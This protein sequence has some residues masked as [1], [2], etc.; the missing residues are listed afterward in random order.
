MEADRIDITPIEDDFVEY[1]PTRKSKHPNSKINKSKQK[2]KPKKQHDTRLPFSKNSIIQILDNDNYTIDIKM[3][4]LNDLLVLISF[5]KAQY[6]K[7]TEWSHG[8]VNI[9]PNQFKQIFN[10]RGGAHT[11]SDKIKTFNMPVYAPW[12]ELK[13]GDTPELINRINN[14][15]RILIN[16]SDGSGMYRNY[17][18]EFFNLN[19]N[20]ISLSVLD[21]TWDIDLWLSVLSHIPSI[22]IYSPNMINILA[23]L[24]I[25]V[26]RSYSITLHKDERKK[27]DIY[28]DIKNYIN[29]IYYYMSDNNLFAMDYANY[30]SWPN[31]IKLAM[32]AIT[33][34]EI[35]FYFGSNKFYRINLHNLIYDSPEE[36]IKY[37]INIIYSTNEK[38]TVEKDGIFELE[39]A[40]VI[41]I[42]IVKLIY[43]ILQMPKEVDIKLNTYRIFVGNEYVIYHNKIHLLSTIF[44]YI[45]GIDRQFEGPLPKINRFC[46]LWNVIESYGTKSICQS[47]K[48]NIDDVKDRLDDIDYIYNM[49]ES[50]Q[51][52]LLGLI[53]IIGYRLL[54]TLQNTIEVYMN[55]RQ[56]GIME[57]FINTPI[58]NINNIEIM[59][60]LSK[61]DRI[62]FSYVS[63]E[64]IQNVPF[65]FNY[66][67]IKLY[68]DRNAKG[69]INFEMLPTPLKMNKGFNTIL[70]RLFDTKTPDTV[71]GYS[72]DMG[73]PFDG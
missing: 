68:R 26:I 57:K 46:M 49:V 69:L 8:I 36:A 35:K 70:T 1:K 51:T 13:N 38:R 9:T 11:I 59:F 44:K 19:N 63:G 23:A 72:F 45:I 16:H 54:S 66:T 17:S 55:N 53:Q 48:I 42:K 67:P 39:D 64:D 37:I 7:F 61:E 31:K 30:A 40:E 2:S 47:R 29:D 12:I 22:Q 21:K 20:S 73:F 10:F 27:F 41:N 33:E 18:N 4:M 3:K 58:K 52:S 15:N 60:S 62:W 5:V 56:I 32:D 65:K 34:G 50:T 14:E 6:G 71:M 28:K 25:E 43:N 24:Y